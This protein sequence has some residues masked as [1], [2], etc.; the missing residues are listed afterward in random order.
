ML[1]LHQRLK[2]VPQTGVVRWVGVRPEHG[3]PMRALEAVTA[4][5]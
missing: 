4:L 1:P 2:I 5:T 3:E